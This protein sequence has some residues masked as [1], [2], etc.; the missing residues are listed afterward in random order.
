MWLCGLALYLPEAALGR[1]GHDE[2]IDL[3]LPSLPVTVFIGLHDR[4]ALKQMVGTGIVPPIHVPT[5]S[6]ADRLARWREVIPHAASDEALDAS[7]AEVARRFRSE[8]EFIERVGAEVTA[9]GR[10]P[11]AEDLLAACRHD[12]ELGALAQQ[13][14]PRFRLDELMLPAAQIP[15]SRN[16]NPASNE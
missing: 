11:C 5:L 16:K 9:L 3:P 12:V 7:V 15:T 8:G 10:P 4:A 1:R 2:V 13:V 14:T 6:Y